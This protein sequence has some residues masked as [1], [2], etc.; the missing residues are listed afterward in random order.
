ML[1]E[2]PIADLPPR[3]RRRI[4]AEIARFT[5][6]PTLREF[7]ITHRI[8]SDQQGLEYT[9]AITELTAAWRAGH[10]LR[11]KVLHDGSWAWAYA[12]PE[13]VPEDQR[14]EYETATQGGEP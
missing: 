10:L 12:R 13:D 3:Q 1:S 14:H 5:R 7:E 4:A 8:Y 6:R 9:H 11:R 2:Q